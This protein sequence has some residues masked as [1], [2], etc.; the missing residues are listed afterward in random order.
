MIRTVLFFP[1]KET[2]GNLFDVDLLHLLSN[3]AM[4]HYGAELVLNL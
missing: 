3:N 2:S 1:E 4:Y